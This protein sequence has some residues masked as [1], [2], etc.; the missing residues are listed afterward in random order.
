MRRKAE[1]ERREAAA[2][3]KSKL[4][5][6]G[7][8][9]SE[10]GISSVILPKKDKRTVERQLESPECG[11]RYAEQSALKSETINK[12]VKLLHQYFSGER[13]SFDLPLDLRNYTRFQQAVWKAAAEIPYGETRSYVWIASRIRNPRASRAVGQALG[14]NPIPVII[15]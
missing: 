12:A 14:A 8:A 10:K 5:W 3:F 1:G 2:I 9:V 15:P 6:A 11:V 4:G 13:V 7:V